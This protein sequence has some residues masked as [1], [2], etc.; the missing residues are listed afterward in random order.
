MS[1]QQVNFASD[2]ASPNNNSI[3]QTVD[4]FNFW[5]KKFVKFYRNINSHYP[6]TSTR[7]KSIPEINS[8]EWQPTLWHQLNGH[9]L[10]TTA[11]IAPNMSRD[12]KQGPENRFT[13]KIYMGQNPRWHPVTLWPKFTLMTINQL[14]LH[15]TQGCQT[16]RILQEILSIFYGR[17]RI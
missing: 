12:W 3:R 17:S 5:Q 7:Q 16:S 15:L 14:L 4:I 11:Y 1:G 10:V 8:R 6:K 13:T 2:T 9:N